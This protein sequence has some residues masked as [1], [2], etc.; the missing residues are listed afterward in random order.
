MFGGE[1]AAAMASLQA[2]NRGVA[3]LSVAGAA[4]P[5]GALGVSPAPAPAKRDPIDRLKELADLHTSGALT[6]A[7]FE[8]QKAKILAET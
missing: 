6:D 3:G 5:L 2:M 4:S 1:P 7:E 8:S